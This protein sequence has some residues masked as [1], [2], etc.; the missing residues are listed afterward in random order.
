MATSL[1]KKFNNTSLRASYREE[2]GYRCEV[3]PHLPDCDR[4]EITGM[5]KTNTEY[6]LELHHI[7][8]QPKYRVDNWSN[9][10]M[11][12]SVVHSAFGHN[13]RMKELTVA[14]LY[15]KFC[16]AEFDIHELSAATAK[17][18]IQNEIMNL[19]NNLGHRPDYQELCE[20]ML[21]TLPQI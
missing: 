17:P 1:K 15:A 6:G 16:K 9:F 14:C 13:K 12:S 10:I 5:R 18:T 3:W 4:H 2:N 8:R 19:R 20:K 21:A 7:L 11:I